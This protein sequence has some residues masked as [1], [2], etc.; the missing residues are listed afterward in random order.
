MIRTC[1]LNMFIFYKLEVHDTTGR[2]QVACSVP[3]LDESEQKFTRGAHFRTSA[4]IIIPSTALLCCD[5]VVYKGRDQT[6][7]GTP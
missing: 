2:W 4:C 5:I 6:R 1:L 7:P 3:D